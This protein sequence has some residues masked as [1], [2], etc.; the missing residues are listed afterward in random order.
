MVGLTRM[1]LMHGKLGGVGECRLR[2]KQVPARLLVFGDRLQLPDCDFCR[3]LYRNIRIMAPS[4]RTSKIPI[5]ESLQMQMASFRRHLWRLRVVEAVAAGVMGLLFSF[6][7]V[8]LLD[9]VWPTPGWLRLLILG[10]G[11]SL[12]AVFAPYW[13][14]RWVWGQRR[15][16]QLARLIAKRYPGL[17]DRLLGVIELQE[18]CEGAST[19]S[20]RLREAAMLAVSAEVAARSLEDALPSSSHRRWIG[21]AL[22]LTILVLVACVAMPKAGWNALQRW[23]FPLSK[24]ERYTFTRLANAPELLVVPIGEAFEVELRLATD[25]EQHPAEASGAYEGQREVKADLKGDVYRFV[26]PGQQEAGTIEFR[27]GDMRHSLRIEPRVRPAV[28][29][30]EAIVTP[31]AYLGLG[32]KSMDCSAGVLSVVS[33]S[34]VRFVLKVDK[35]LRFGTCGPVKTV[36]DVDQNPTNGELAQGVNLLIDGLVASSGGI[37]I[38]K[39]HLEI[40]FEWRDCDG[41]EGEAGYRVRVDS[42]ED[43]APLCYLQGIDRQRVM[44]PE[45]TVNFELMAEDDFGVKI[46]G[47]EWVGEFGRP[48]GGKPAKGELQ[49]ASGAAGVG[50]LLE[51]V[52]FSPAAFRIGPQKIVLRAYVEDFFPGRARSYSEPVILH[53]LSRDEHAQMLKKQFDRHIGD[54]QDLARREI[55]LL[56]ENE[57]LGAMEGVELEKGENRQRL[58]MQAGEEAETRRRMEDLAQ[59]FEQLMK[60]AA[61]NGQIDKLTLRKLAETQRAVHELSSQD[62]PALEQKLAES[63]DSKNTAEKSAK[64]LDSVIEIQRKA[65]EKMRDAIELAN[66]ANKHF[67]AGTFV[68]R[69]KKAAGEQAGIVDSLKES[70]VRILGLGYR[71]LDPADAR[72]VDESSKQQAATASDLRWLQEDMAH[73][74]ARTNVEPIQVLINEMK[75]SGMDSDLEEIRARLSKNHS[76]EAAEQSKKWADQLNQWAIQLGGNTS[77]AAGAGAGSAPD[78]ENEDFEFMLRMMKMIQSEQDLRAQ[79]RVL[80]QFRRSIG[81]MPKLPENR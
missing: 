27:A 43:V 20:P 78:A 79:T 10:G 23:I 50:R 11:I 16:V 74:F 53:V 21:I 68:S 18:Q 52:A 65:L 3:L 30:I 19:I 24:T 34:K 17:G 7:L 1:A 62:I 72:K 66:D 54:L 33:G 41:L 8:M 69:L 39:E 22:V 60:D 5:P 61:R 45:E 13:L 75:Q 70:F 29:G 32:E 31:P 12:F 51:T 25:S 57:R 76:F 2:R 9:R 81:S 59:R 80:E 26:F 64:D 36:S 48:T 6:L 49:L 44:L 55:G 46:A 56:D 4:S 73:Y 47:I 35:P 38:G 63:C 42:T 71:R 77:E 28:R 67:E 58:G 37:M 15:D 40:P 14:H